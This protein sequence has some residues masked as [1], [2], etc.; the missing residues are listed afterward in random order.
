VR[1][2][3]TMLNV[4]R[5]IGQLF[6]RSTHGFRQ[7]LCKSCLHGSRWAMASSSMWMLE[8]SESVSLHETYRHTGGIQTLC[9]SKCK[10]GSNLTFQ[11]YS[12]NI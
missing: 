7:E 9:R 12:A 2:I 11:A 6:A 5:H 3:S 8:N 1:L 4:V 10:A